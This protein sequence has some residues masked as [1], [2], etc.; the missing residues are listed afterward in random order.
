MSPSRL[1]LV[2]EIRPNIRAGATGAD[3]LATHNRQCSHLFQY[4]SGGWLRRSTFATLTQN[5]RTLLSSPK[6]RGTPTYCGAAESCG[7]VTRSVVWGKV[8]DS[9][10][11]EHWGR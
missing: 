9:V 6:I 7:H 5:P 1:A 4:V 2:G 10:R 8:P 11:V 3:K